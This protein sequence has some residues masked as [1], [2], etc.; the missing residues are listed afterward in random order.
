[1]TR[2]KYI[3][4]ETNVSEVHLEMSVNNMSAGVDNNARNGI[5]GDAKTRYP[6]EDDD[7]SSFG[8]LW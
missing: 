3:K 4:P 7:D 8:N 6:S 2:A 1:M 5:S